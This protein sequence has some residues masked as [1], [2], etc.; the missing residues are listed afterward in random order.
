[1]TVEERTREVH[2]LTLFA[3]EGARLLMLGSFPPPRERW[4]MDFF[5]PNFQ[6]DM[7]RIFGLVF[8]GDKSHFL[9]DDGRAFRE[10]ELRRFLTE[11]GIAIWDTAMEVSRLQ[12]NASD[13]FLEVLRPIDL[14]QT[15]ALLP[16][17]R[18]IAVTGQKALDT[19][20]T[21]VSAPSPPPKTGE[22]TD[23]ALDDRHFRLYRMPSSSRA[24][25]LSVEKKAEKYRRMFEEMGLK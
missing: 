16:S 2:P 5:Y 21:L 23:A 24:Y 15:L 14:R 25:P 17:C 8:F 3:P 13:K 1:M 12:G 7:W 22:W 10:V 20:L 11:R 19:L 6:N 9:T 18:A 4:R